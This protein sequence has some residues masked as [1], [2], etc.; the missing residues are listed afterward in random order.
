MTSF[1]GSFLIARPV[2]KDPSFKETV[3]LLIQHTAEGAFGLV[4]NRPAK[5][6]ELPFPIFK[7]GPC[8]SQGLFMLHGHADW[9]AASDVADKVE[10]A[11]GIYL[12]DAASVERVQETPHNPKLRYRMFNGYAGWGPGQLESELATG[13]WAVA[14]A[15]G[16]ALF[17]TPIAEMWISLVPPTI[18]QP[19]LN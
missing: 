14:P 4:V 11:S 6:K 16:Q 18:P 13:A 12:G 19:S 10:V 3:V 2:L 9:A 8:P 15:S 5:K 1:A 7:G 17:E